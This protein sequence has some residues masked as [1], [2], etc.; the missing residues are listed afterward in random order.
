MTEQK[1]PM[2]EMHCQ[3]PWFS[4]IRNK[5]KP[6]EGRKNTPKHQKIKVG[7]YIRFCN[8]KDNFL[9]IVTEIKHYSSL[10]TYLHDVSPGIALPNIPSFDEAKKIYLQWST[11]EEIKKWGFLGIFV[12][13]IE[14]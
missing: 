10:D 9:T 5:I 7:D 14:D 8:G 3:E 6:V 11:E 2:H 13:V 1:T 4:Y 12:K